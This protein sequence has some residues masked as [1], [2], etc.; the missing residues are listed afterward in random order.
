M[1][2]ARRQVTL[3]LHV[4]VDVLDQDALLAAATA[5]RSLPELIAHLYATNAA[6]AVQSLLAPQRVVEDIPGVAYR[7]CV[8][9]A[10]DT[11]PD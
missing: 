8:F 2:E 3:T 10:T 4:T 9:D 11:T 1:A 6:A 5:D 7:A